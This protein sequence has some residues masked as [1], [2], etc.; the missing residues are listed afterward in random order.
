MRA[1]CKIIINEMLEAMLRALQEI[2]T[3][4]LVRDH[5]LPCDQCDTLLDELA[6]IELRMVNPSHVTDKARTLNHIV[7][8]LVNAGVVTE[9]VWEILSPPVISKVPEGFESYREE[10]GSFGLKERKEKG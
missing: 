9:R 1:A 10:D 3:S 2:L 7:A 8:D 5:M 6:T 4:P